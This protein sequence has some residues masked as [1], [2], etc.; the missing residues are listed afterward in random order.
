MRAIFPWRGQAVDGAAHAAKFSVEIENEAEEGAGNP[1]A[2]NQH[3]SA[4]K[5]QNVLRACHA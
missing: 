2:T 4:V 1:K 5:R 3:R